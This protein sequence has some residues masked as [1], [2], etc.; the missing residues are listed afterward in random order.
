MKKQCKYWT[1]S[2][3]IKVITSN[4]EAVFNCADIGTIITGAGISTSKYSVD[5]TKDIV[6]ELWQTYFAR[7]YDYYII[8]KT[9]CDLWEDIQISADEVKAWLIKFMVILANTYPYYSELLTE[10]K[11]AS[12]HLMD[13]IRATNK[14]KV[15][16][17]ETPQN[18][19]S[20]G[21]YES[22]DYLTH[23][24]KTEGEQSSQ[25]EPKVIR[26]KQIQDSFKRVM[27]DWLLEFDSL[28]LFAVG[29]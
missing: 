8:K 22:E 29:D 9:S 28:I 21:T 23:F 26:L 3:G 7:Y 6:K 24:T 1:L 19:N 20:S 2:E 25:L 27:N 16:F 11:S 14:N 17:N 5:L 15:G 10:Y 12:T 18:L 4:D 13:D